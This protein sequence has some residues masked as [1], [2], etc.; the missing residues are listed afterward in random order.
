MP[1]LCLPKSYHEDPLELPAGFSLIFQSLCSWMPT[2]MPFSMAVCECAR[3][4]TGAR[5]YV[6][7]SGC[8]ALSRMAQIRLEVK[9]VLGCEHLPSLIRSSITLET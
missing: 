1:P 6:S 3:A 2:V 5:M 9:Y 7:E 8:P 4:S